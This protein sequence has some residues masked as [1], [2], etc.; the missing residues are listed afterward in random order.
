MNTDMKKST[1][2]VT[3]LHGFSDEEISSIMRLIKTQF[4]EQRPWLVFAKSTPTSL[5]TPL[6]ELIADMSADHEY[7]KKNPPQ[8]YRK[9]T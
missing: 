5:N 4:S 6:G 9:N 3:I 1:H 7:L 8:P 2:K